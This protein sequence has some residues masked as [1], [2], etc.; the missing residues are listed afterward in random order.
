ML[1]E[2]TWGF[3]QLEHLP[4]TLFKSKQNGDRNNQQSAAFHLLSL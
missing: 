2:N 1:R 4:S 3:Q